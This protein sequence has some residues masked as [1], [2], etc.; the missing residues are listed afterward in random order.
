MWIY[1]AAENDDTQI[2]QLTNLYK[3][4]TTVIANSYIVIL[5]TL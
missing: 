5:N 3:R 1:P 2:Q 4:G